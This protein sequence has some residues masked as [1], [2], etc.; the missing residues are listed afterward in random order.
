[1]RVVTRGQRQF[2]PIVA[3][4]LLQGGEVGL[5][6]GD[7]GVDLGALRRRRLAKEKK[8]LTFATDRARISRG[9]AQFGLLLRGGGAIA[10]RIATAAGLRNLGLS[11]VA[12]R[13]K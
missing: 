3:G 7:A 12:F 10:P 4:A 8:L 11:V 2:P 6:L 9:A 13:A 1:L 5:H